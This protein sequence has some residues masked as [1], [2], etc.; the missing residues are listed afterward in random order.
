VIPQIKPLPELFTTEKV[1]LLLAT[2]SHTATILRPGKKA[3][4]RAKSAVSKLRARN[5]RGCSLLEVTPPV[6]P[7]LLLAVFSPAPAD[8]LA[9]FLA[10]YIECICS[11]LLVPTCT[12]TE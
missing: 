9:L 12:Q 2:G 10:R 6:A 11:K 7:G 1:I 8:S 5:Y 3:R 4:Q